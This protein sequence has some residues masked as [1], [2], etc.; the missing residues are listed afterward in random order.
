M[1]EEIHILER[2]TE[3]RCIR[4]VLGPGN[5]CMEPEVRDMTNREGFCAVYL[6]KL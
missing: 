2:R 5:S 3:Q 4:Y 1:R 6:E